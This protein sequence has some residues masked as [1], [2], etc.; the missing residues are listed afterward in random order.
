M[1]RHTTRDG[2]PAQQRLLQQFLHAQLA[3]QIDAIC[4]T[5]ATGNAHGDTYLADSQYAQSLGVAIRVMLTWHLH[6]L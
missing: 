6:W 5:M 1:L 2:A 4:A 3:T